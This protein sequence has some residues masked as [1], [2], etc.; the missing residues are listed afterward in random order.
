MSVMTETAPDL[1]EWCRGRKKIYFM[2]WQ[3]RAEALIDDDVVPAMLRVK[4]TP[5]QAYELTN[6]R[7]TRHM[8]DILPDL[9]VSVREVF[10][11]GKT[12]AEWDAMTDG[13]Y[14]KKLRSEKGY[15]AIKEK[16]KTLGYEFE[17]DT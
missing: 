15:A 8:Q 12:P 14:Q 2:I 6:E 16:L 3:D 1:I 4:L 10:I 17:G 7:R 11:S 5:E 13:Q 9:P